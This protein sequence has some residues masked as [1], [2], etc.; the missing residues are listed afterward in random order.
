MIHHTNG[1]VLRQ[2]KYGETSLI[3][4][5]YTELFGRQSYIINGVRV[6]GKNNKAQLYQPGS[7]LD[8]QVYHNEL[9]NLQ[10]IREAKWS[11]IYR[12]IYSDVVKNGVA[13]YMV[14]LILKSVQQPESNPEL[15]AFCENSFL[16]LDGASAYLTANFP[17][18]FALHLAKLLGFEL[19][20]NHNAQHP[21]FDIEEGSFVS[22]YLK[23]TT[24]Q[25]DKMS[26]FI[27]QL[28]SVSDPETLEELRMPTKMKV[29]LLHELEK[30]YQWH[31]PEFGRIKTMEILPGL[32]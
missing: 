5:I 27:A 14:E 20:N 21:Y 32:F 30:F 15:F 12:H 23:E 28:L 31:I 10:R 11:H 29:S 6:S 18:Y 13:L 26:A 25:S 17:A 19:N 3:V 1:I 2:V 24:I 22:D 8:L 4:T 16:I 9:K 7:L